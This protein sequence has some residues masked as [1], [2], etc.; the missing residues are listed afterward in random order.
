M[1]QHFLLAFVVAHLEKTT[2]FA[3]GVYCT[4]YRGVKIAVDDNNSFQDTGYEI[5]F[6]Y[7]DTSVGKIVQDTIVVH[8]L[9]LMAFAF[10]QQ[11]K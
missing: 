1:I 9:E 7:T 5:Y 10:F 4:G 6:E 11:S 3:T 2:Y 8:Q